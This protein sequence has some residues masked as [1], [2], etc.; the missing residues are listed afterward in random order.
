MKKYFFN[1]L[2][3]LSL[4]FLFFIPLI[5]QADLSSEADNILFGSKGKEVDAALGD[6]GDEDPRVIIANIINILLGFLG[7]IAVVLILLGGFKWMTAA[8]DEQKVEDARKLIYAAAIGLIIIL[9][10]WAI[11]VFVLDKIYNATTT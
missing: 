10:A 1:L 2:T 4:S 6:L 3:F 7:T 11:A 8:G 9:S 5:T